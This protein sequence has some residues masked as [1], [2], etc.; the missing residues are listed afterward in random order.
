MGTVASS[1]DP[2]WC[3][4]SVRTVN[5]DKDKGSGWIEGSK[6]KGGRTHVAFLTGNTWEVTTRHS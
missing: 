2:G 5:E 1:R 3:S 6:S 4:I